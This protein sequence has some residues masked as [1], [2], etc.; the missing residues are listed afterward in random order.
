MCG[1]PAVIK[2][3]TNIR[4]GIVAPACTA[5]N[6]A[7]SIIVAFKG[8]T[9]TLNFNYNPSIISPNVSGISPT[10]FSPVLKGNMTITGLGFGTSASDLTVFLV[11]SIGERTYQMNV[12][13]A[14]DTEL[15]VKIPGGESGTFT[16][17][18]NRAG[19]GDSSETTT[20]VA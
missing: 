13:S 7:T 2:S 15:L 17:I 3:V 10:S 20:G 8:Q 19:Y 11:N 16:V 14:S 5:A 12:L 6:A 18:V 9:A 4:I 1:I